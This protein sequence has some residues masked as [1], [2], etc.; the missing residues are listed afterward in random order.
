MD[1]G[2]VW[3]AMVTPFDSKGKLDLDAGAN[4]IDHLITTGTDALVV[5]GTTGESPTLSAKEKEEL[6]RFVITYT[7]KRVPVILGTGTNDTASSVAMSKQ[8]TALGA[9]GIM[10]VVP[11]YNRPSQTG[12]FAHFKEIAASVSLPVMLYNVPHRT[13]AHMLPETV[14]ALSQLPNITALKEASGDLEQM[15]AIIEQTDED[16]FVYSGDDSMALPALSIGAHGVVSVASHVIGEQMQELVTAFKTGEIER[17]AQLHRFLLPKMKALFLAP[18]PVCVKHILK[19]T[20]VDAGATR[21]PLI[22]LSPE[23]EVLVESFFS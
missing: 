8:A 18:N 22:S 10:A 6:F 12:M 1:F 4:L 17:A 9:D 21:M 7:N 20:G 19:Q 11:Y 13:G 16:F 5:A 14:I 2:H 23:E 3:T 15:A